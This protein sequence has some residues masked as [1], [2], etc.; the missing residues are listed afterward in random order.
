MGTE[1]CQQ[2]DL[3]AQGAE[4]RTGSDPVDDVV[5]DLQPAKERALRP[6]K[7]N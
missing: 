7:K 6:L 3:L 5:G 1:L 4:E 2:H